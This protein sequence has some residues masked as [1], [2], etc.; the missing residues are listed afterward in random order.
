[1]LAFARE[2]TD[3]AARALPEDPVLAGQRAEALLL[4]GATAAALELWEKI[5][6]RD[7]AAR[8]LAALILCEAVE[9]PTTHAPDE[10]ADEQVASRAF[11][12]W[13]QKLIAIRSQTL[14]TRVNEQLDKLARAL[15][16]AAQMLEAALKEV[17]LPTEV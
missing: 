16:T 1:L 11:I 7:H 15:P 17:E 8:S 5:W 13:Y 2:W 12:E 10:G 14:T 4:N 6:N 9:S 3:E